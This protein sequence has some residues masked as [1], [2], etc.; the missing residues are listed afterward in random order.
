ME[1]RLTYEQG[2]LKIFPQAYSH[3]RQPK[4]IEVDELLWG[5]S[6]AFRKFAEGIIDYS[7]TYMEELCNDPHFM[8]ENRTPKLEMKVELL[9]ETKK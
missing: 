8:N 7:K 6:P 1:F 9:M 4:E 2:E 5:R 3:E